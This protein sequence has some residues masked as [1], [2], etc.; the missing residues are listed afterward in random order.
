VKIGNPLDLIRTSQPAP[1]GAAPQAEKA[2]T[3]KAD[4]AA[5]QA[6]NGS[7][8]VKLS[9]GLADLTA[10]KQDSDGFDAKRVEQMK[11][12]IADGSFK[13]DAAVVADQVIASNLD[14][15]SHSKP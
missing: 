5:A 8:S 11:A 2:A 10:D 6:T 4:G 12:A 7:A 14:A 9:S 13:V 3:A 15:L 1:G